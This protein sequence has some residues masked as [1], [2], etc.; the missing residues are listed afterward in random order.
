VLVA[1][2]LGN[3]GE[4]YDRTR[5]NVGKRV[6]GSLIERLRLR[7]SP[8]KGDYCFAEATSRNLVLVIPTIFMNS[9]GHAASRVLEQ[10]GM[11]CEDLLVVCDDFY[12][13]LGAVRLRK[14][15][16][17]GGHKGLA[18]IIYEL[19]SQNFGRLRV[20]VGMPP[21]D[22]D[23]ADFVLSGFGR[24]EEPIMEKTLAAAGEAVLAAADRGI[25][26]AMNVYNKRTEGAGGALPP[27]GRVDADGRGPTSGLEA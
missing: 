10:V 12:L 24:E 1:L 21:D 18:S 20:G 23:P 11:G 6:V 22:V 2:G 27:S 19:G 13:P 25:G 17:D 4:R 9:S 15:G 16:G 7:A 14:Q 3:P 8:G 26:W 5:H